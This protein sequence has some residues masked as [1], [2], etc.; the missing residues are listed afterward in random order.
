MNDRVTV[1][2]V[3]RADPAET[4]RLFT[5]EIDCWWKRGPQ[6]RLQEGAM[7]FDSDRLLEGDTEVG[8]VLAWDPGRRLALEFRNWRFGRG[9]PSEVEVRFE[10]VGDGTRVTVEHR[11][12]PARP[13]GAGEFRTVVGLWWGTLLAGFQGPAL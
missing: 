5:N 11:G 2:T 8:R 3:V 1:T 4:F 13:A 9:E 6:F 10:A 12:W 7:R